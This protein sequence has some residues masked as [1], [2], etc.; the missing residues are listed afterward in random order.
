MHRY[1]GAF[2]EVKVTDHIGVRLGFDRVTNYQHDLFALHAPHIG[3]DDLPQV[4]VDLRFQLHP[5]SQCRSEQARVAPVGADE[6][7][8][9]CRPSDALAL[10]AQSKV[11]I[12]CSSDLLEQNGY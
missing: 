4:L 3:L 10:A 6:E 7:E 12:F 11:S 8:I 1:G 5:L 2:E 9:D